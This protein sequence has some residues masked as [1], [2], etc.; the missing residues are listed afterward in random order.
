MDFFKLGKLSSYL[1]QYPYFVLFLIYLLLRF[2]FQQLTLL[3][4]AFI[5]PTGKIIDSLYFSGEYIHG[6]WIYYLINTK[7]I[8]G[9]SC[10]GTTFFSL[11]TAYLTFLIVKENISKKWL[12][13]TFPITILA[14]TIRVI[15]SM[16]AHQFTVSIKQ[17]HLSDLVHVAVGVITFLCCFMSIIFIIQ[18]KKHYE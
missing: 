18:Y 7:F 4:Q 10:S 5:Y 9:E 17:A 16:Y 6:E 3:K 12:I 2:T 15:S 11:I 8:L 13:L 1:K 14:N